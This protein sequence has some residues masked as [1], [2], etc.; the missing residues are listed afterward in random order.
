MEFMASHPVQNSTKSEEIS[1]LMSTN[2][3]TQH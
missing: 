2:D 3:F 1:N